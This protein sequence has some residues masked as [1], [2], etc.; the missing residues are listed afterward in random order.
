MLPKI[1][2]LMD[3][4]GKKCGQYVRN[5]S[6]RELRA[7]DVCRYS[8]GVESPDY[9]LG[10]AILYKPL[11]VKAVVLV[12]SQYDPV[13]TVANPQRHARQITYESQSLWMSWFLSD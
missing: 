5:Q 7:S 2:N 3:D 4:A 1:V 10:D 8:A 11:G 9:H 12:A 13:S 6:A